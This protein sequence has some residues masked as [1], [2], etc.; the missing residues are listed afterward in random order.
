MGRLWSNAAVF[1]Q[2]AKQN[3]NGAMCNQLSIPLKWYQTN[4]LRF[5][6]WTGQIP[7]TKLMHYTGPWGRGSLLRTKRNEKLSTSDFDV[8]DFTR[9]EAAS[10]DKTAEPKAATAFADEVERII[11]VRPAIV[12]MGMI[13]HKGESLVLELSTTDKTMYIDPRGRVK[14]SQDQ[15]DDDVRKYEEMIEGRKPAEQGQVAQVKILC[16]GREGS[17][18]EV[19][20]V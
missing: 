4:L 14:L 15:F 19:A 20:P 7:Q 2:I 6:H 10:R 1:V 18:L 16:G 17:F 3:A 8:L 13:F 11:T 9:P 5:V 12:P